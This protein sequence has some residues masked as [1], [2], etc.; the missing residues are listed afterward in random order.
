MMEVRCETEG[1]KSLGLYRLVVDAKEPCPR[2]GEEVKV[3]HH[4]AWNDF[5]VP[6]PGEDDVIQRVLAPTEE[7]KCRS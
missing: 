4:Y 7:G 2:C 6:P 1:C 3:V 5:P